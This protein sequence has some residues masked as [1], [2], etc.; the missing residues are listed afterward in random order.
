MARPFFKYSAQQLEE[1][2]NSDGSNP[3]TLKLLKEELDHRSTNKARRLLSKVEESFSKINTL[4]DGIQS[5]SVIPSLDALQ[6]ELFPSEGVDSQDGVCEHD[7]SEERNP[8]HER[9]GEGQQANNYTSP[10]DLSMPKVMTRM[11]PCGT[12]GLPAAYVRQL[13]HDVKLHVN[14][15]NIVDL[16]IAAVSALISEM[17]RTSSGQKRYEVENGIRIIEPALNDTRY[18]FAFNDEADLFED[19]DITI[20][21][22]GQRYEGSIVSISVSVRLKSPI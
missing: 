6:N 11:R 10:D 2:F 15:T 20:E 22:E 12:S 1:L 14:D 3:E 18:V 8:R 17:K 5:K 13:S 4:T 19:A 9:A 16:Y 7:D 21:I